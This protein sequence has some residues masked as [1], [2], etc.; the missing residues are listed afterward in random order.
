[1]QMAFWKIA[2][3]ADRN[4]DLGPVS[5]AALEVE[6]SDP[7]RFCATGIEFGRPGLA[8]YDALLTDQ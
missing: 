3:S 6:D 1:M 2:D 5:A 4:V 7:T 8:V